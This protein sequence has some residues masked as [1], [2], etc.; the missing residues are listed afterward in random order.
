MP[1]PQFIGVYMGQGMGVLAVSGL[2]GSPIAGAIISRYGFASGVYFAGASMVVGTV[3]VVTA[4]LCWSRD[5][6]AAH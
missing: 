4:R 5:L 1:K 2:T 3:L 6:M